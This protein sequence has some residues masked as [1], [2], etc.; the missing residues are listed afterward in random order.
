MS[1]SVRLKIA[2]LAG[3]GLAASTGVLRAATVSVPNASFESPTTGLASPH[4][5]SWQKAP[6]PDWYTE[7]GGFT[8]DQLA[9]VFTNQ[10]VTASDYIDNCD[11]TQAG[12]MFAIPQVALFQDYNSIDWAH[13]NATHDFNAFFETGKAYTLTV[14]VIGGG[15]GMLPGASLDISLYYRDAASN[16]VPVAT[17]SI[18]NSPTIFSNNTHFI[19]FRVPLPAVKAADAWAG[20]HIGVQLLSTVSSN[21][22]G[23]YW[24]VDNVRLQSVTPPTLLGA[25]WT[26]GHFSFALQ[27]EPGLGFEILASTNLTFPLSNWTSLGMVTNIT[28][29][30]PFLD[31]AGDLGRRFYKAR[32]LP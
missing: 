18:S 1:I 16:M 32:L 10:P 27:S 25:A 2:V 29:T 15:G 5:D 12:Y 30:V 9:G 7:S 17:T 14:G 20:Q 23:G 21:L 26:N 4:V 31:P 11:G 22:E 28:G 24:D 6:K 3:I 19:D 8:W 13:T